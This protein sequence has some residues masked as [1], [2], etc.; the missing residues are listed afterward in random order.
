[1]NILTHIQ[2]YLIY[3]LTS[4]DKS[5]RQFFIFQIDQHATMIEL[6]IDVSV[7]VAL[8]RCYHI[9]VGHTLCSDTELIECRAVQRDAVVERGCCVVVEREF[10][11]VLNVVREMNVL[12]CVWLHIK[13]DNDSN[14]IYK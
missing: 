9:V 2:I 3:K 1:M 7:V 11:A 13:I 14:Q 10:A 12:R 5:T 8:N 4:N 6:N